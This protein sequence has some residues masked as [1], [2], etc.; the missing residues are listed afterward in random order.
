V[1]APDLR[2]IADIAP[3]V[4][5]KKL[6]PVELVVSCL[7]EIAAQREVNAFTTVL[8]SSALEEAR[9]ADSEMASGG[10]RGPLH[11][12]PIAVKDLIDVAG[13]RTTS[14][15]AVP[16]VEARADAPVVKRLREA[17]AIVIGKTNLHE[18]A[19][20]TT[21]EE[22][23]FGPV[24]NP[25]DLSRSA[26]GSSGGSA[27]ALAA[28]MCFGAI[29]TDT[30][31]SIRIPSAACG[32]VGLKPT[33][34]ELPIDGIVP[35]SGSFDHVGPMARSVADAVLLFQAMQGTTP[36]GGEPSVERLRFGIP[37]RYFCDRVDDDVASSLRRAR[38]A[39]T[40]AGHQVVDIEIAH[41]EWTPDVYLH[42]MLP[43]ASWYHAPLLERHASS[44]SPGVRLRLEM[45]RY[46]RA[47]DY[48]RAQTLRE[49]LRGSVNA[50]MA[51]S[52][53][54]AILLPTLPT[55]APPLGAQTVTIAGK[56]EP[57]RGAMLRLTQMF[58]VTGHPSIAFPA[59]VGGDGMPRG[60]QLVGREHATSS[61]L[62]A[63]LA[64]ERQIS[65]GAGSVGGGTG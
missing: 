33:Y 64:V 41:A 9:H 44:Y 19:Y 11:G 34:G 7:E 39:L 43:E 65:G 30:G 26:G 15:S 6:S 14:G 54:D 38:T 60:L 52:R 1:S 58:N 3:L 37:Q 45:G 12:I 16:S 4:R 36:T 48:V 8:E 47:E 35:L 28:G 20:G 18:F 62:R 63:A 50:A 46:V 5:S 21:S 10:W 25:L 51:T 27:A 56:P 32:T 17:G 22:T 49:V 55:A 57:I 24:K 42:I 2:R 59:G 29:G 23:A 40:E 13:T 53:L 61:L 31:G